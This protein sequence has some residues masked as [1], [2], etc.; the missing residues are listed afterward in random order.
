MTDA[1]AIRHL[2]FDMGGV[3]IDID[4]HG[5]ISQLL[6]RDIPFEQIHALWGA[7]DA[8]HAFETGRTD[9]D[10]FT[11]D[12]IEEQGLS[13]SAGA[14]QQTFRDIIVDVFPGVNEL[15]IGLKPNYTLSLLSN[16]N[17]AHWQQVQSDYDFIP[18]FDNP[19]TSIE[20]GVMKPDPEIYRQLI[21]E[22][23][24]EPSSILFFDD[25]ARNIQ[26]AR[27]IGMHAEQV[28]NPEDIR[29]VL[30]D[31]RLIV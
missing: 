21:A 14:F 28:F 27:K 10:R 12:F 25:G 29:R 2:V 13:L 18:L 5:K 30:R 31:Y 17:R 22:L 16:T 26:E 24:A 3:L 1:N 23:G 20:F 9:F 8:V 19:F 15:L 4:W 7:S 6:G 11:R